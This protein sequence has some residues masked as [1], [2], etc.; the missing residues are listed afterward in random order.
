[1]KPPDLMGGGIVRGKGHKSLP[2]S[3][4]MLPPYR[5]ASATKI[6]AHCPK[7]C[8]K[9]Y[10]MALTGA[11]SLKNAVMCMCWHCMGWE[12]AEVTRCTAYGCPL[13]AYRPK[14]KT[15]GADDERS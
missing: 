15:E 11:K 10:A 9:R 8:Q 5:G 7:H 12:R 1:M 4:L 3:I 2:E 13:W 6:A 14:R